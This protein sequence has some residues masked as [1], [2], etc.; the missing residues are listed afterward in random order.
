MGKTYTKESIESLSPLEFTRLRPG[1]YCGS[2][3]YSTQLVVELFS[4]ALD[5][6]NL[7]HGDTIY[8]TIQNDNHIT[9]RDNGQGFLINELREDGKTV[10]EAAF[11]VLNTSGKYRDDGVY[12]GTSLGLNGIGSKLAT[13]LS[14]WLKVITWKNDQFEE[15]QFVEGVFSKRQT[16][17]LENKINLGPSGTMISFQ[18]S[19][20]FFTHAEPDA[21][22]LEKMFNDIC[23]LCP[24]LTIKFNDKIIHH[25]EGME[26]LVKDKVGKDI[27]ICD[28][29]FF[30]EKNNKTQ[31]TCGMTYTSKS[32]ND[33][34]AY[35]NYGLTDA[36]PHITAIKSCI[37]RTLNK[38]A[39]EN[40]VLKK[41]ETNLD[42]TSLQEGLVL[43][44]NLISPGISYDAQTKSRIVSNDFVPFLN[45]V[46]SSQL[47][48]WLDN[49]PNDAR[50]ILDKAILARK[51]AE[52]AKKARAAVKNKEEKKKKVLKLPSKLADCYSTNRKQCELYITEGDSASGNLKDVRDNEFQAV[53]PVRGKILNTE[54][55][56]LKQIVANA[57]IM[58]MF[59][60]FGV[61]LV[62][63]DQAKGSY[64]VIYDKSKIRYGKIIMMS[65]ADVDG[66]HIKNL[67][68]TFIWNFIPELFDDGFIYAGIPP[69]FRLT[70]NKEILY[71]KDDDALEDFKKNHD[72]S[73]YQVS[74]LKG[75]GEMSP[76]ETEETLIN[77]DT[78]II[79]QVSISDLGK[80][81]TLFSDLMGDNVTARK[82]FIEDNAEKAGIYV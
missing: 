48:I 60:A 81:E 79:Q 19:E 6:F 15:V 55:A 61:K 51:A 80:A 33:I 62:V 23:G 10:L 75:L 9:I 14:H 16:G 3:E 13:Y 73:K 29:L 35:V 77:P 46:F 56:T 74:R 18:P 49:N 69:L 4:N 52:A 47:E 28:R 39:K 54:K 36:G 31:I 71:L 25:P 64:Q 12:E 58:S 57:E 11:S 63:I 8:V 82:R 5:E 21:K 65:D 27:E 22:Y 24:T 41:N 76:E 53:L 72:I 68:Y 2:T 70:N 32:S 20:E 66:A 7:G 43:V 26:Y 50:N 30:Q 34:V 40:G 59:D 38:W 1:V 17:K 78:R 37:T 67:F 44:F 42:G 45:E